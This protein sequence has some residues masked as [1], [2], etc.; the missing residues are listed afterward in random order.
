MAYFIALPCAGCGVIFTA[1][2]HLVPVAVVNGHREGICQSCVARVNP[3]RKEKGLPEI[4]VA[5]G[6]YEGVAEPTDI[7]CNEPPDEAG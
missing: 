2:P 3:L 5:P 4:V 7:D 1:N 6:A